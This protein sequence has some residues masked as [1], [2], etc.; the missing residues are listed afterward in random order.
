ME[1]NKESMEEEQKNTAEAVEVT[2]EQ[3]E[4]KE[5]EQELDPVAQLEQRVEELEQERDESKEKLL[6]AMAD[7]DNQRKRMQKQKDEWIKYSSENIA[8]DL[9]V[10]LDNFDMAISQ[11]PNEES[12]VLASYHEGVCMNA[13]VMVDVLKKH[14]VVEVEA[15]NKKFDPEYHSAV[16]QVES[17]EHEDQ[18]VMEVFQKGYMIND[19]LLRPSMVKVAIRSSSEKKDED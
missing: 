10:V 6:L 7:F 3:V 18:H 9:L 17:D 5:E 14:G 12:E 1:E 4:D 15:L 19:R 13:K 2:E 8:K 11:K 16:T